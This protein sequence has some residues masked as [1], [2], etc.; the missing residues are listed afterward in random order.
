MTWRA[1]SAAVRQVDYVNTSSDR[2]AD[3][4]G[5]TGDHLRRVPVPIRPVLVQQLK[6]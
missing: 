5:T 1:I 3:E 2:V 4:R 6:A